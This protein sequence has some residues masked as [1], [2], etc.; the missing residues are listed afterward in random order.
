[1]LFRS[2]YSNSQ[3]PTVASCYGSA[4]DPYSTPGAPK[5]WLFTQNAGQSPNDLVML[6]EFDINTRTLTGVTMDLFTLSSNMPGY[7]PGT[8]GDQTIAGGAT[9]YVDANNKFV[10][11]VDFQQS[12]NLVAGLELA[13]AGAPL[14][15]DVRISSISSPS[16]GMALGIEDVIVNVQNL[17]TNAQSNIPFTVTVDG[18]SFYSGTVAGPLAMGESTAVNCGT[19][20]LSEELGVW[21]FEA[22]TMM[23]GDEN[24]ENDCKTKTVTHLE[25]MYCDAST[26]NQDEYISNV[27]C[28]TIDNSS[29][30]QGG[31]ADYTAISTAIAAG[32]TEAITVTN[33]NPWGS[34]KVT[35]WVDWNKNYE[36]DGGDEM[37]VLTSNAGGA[38]FTGNIAVPTGTPEGDYRMRVRMSYSTDPTPCG[39]M[40]YGEVEDYT[41]HV[42]EAA[43][44]DVGVSALNMGGF[45]EPGVV[46]PKA[47]VKN[48]GS[49]TQTFNV[50][51]TIGSYTS[52]KSVTALVSGAT[53]EVTFDS[54]TAT[55]GSYTAEACTQLAGDENPANNCK[56]MSIT[57]ATGQFVYAYNAYD[58]SG[59][60]V[61]GPVTFDVVNPGNM[62]LLAPTST[63]DFIAGAT[64]ANGTWYGCMYGGGLYTI[65]TQTGA[66]VLVGSS[67]DLGGLAWDGTTMYGASTTDLYTI[68]PATGAGT[69]IGA[70]GNASLM[71]GIAADAAGNIYGYDIGDD[72]F[73]SINKTTG[74]ATIV[75]PLG[76]DFNYA[77]DMAYDK[78]NDVCYLAGYTTTG[79]LFSVDVTT[80]AAT[81]LAEFAGGAEITGFAIPDEGT[82]PPVG[83][84]PIN[85]AASYVAGTG[86]N[87]SWEMPAVA[88]D[89]IRWDD[90]ENSGSLGLEE[91]GTFWA[92]ARWEP[93]DLAAFN[94]Q[95]ITE[96][97]LFPV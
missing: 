87:T 55:V 68:D 12:P 48:F 1:M 80:G 83:P 76:H 85:F 9:S 36:F 41:I 21:V 84:P 6:E 16:T 23:A 93:A 35:V 74:A 49:T 60:I 43:A 5:L 13:T 42:G 61:E 69:L 91:P 29:G 45:Y 70:M 62:N 57:V 33:G 11:A 71:I 79:G 26:N 72:N 25:P 77:Q 89:W 30:W 50:T 7:I 90:G 94:G 32:Q 14:T 66:M 24:P 73:Y 38:N 34:D 52:T 67:P 65:D 75:G 39:P 47:T 8:S 78:V 10:I 18:A 86:V 56:S 20:D 53:Q 28:G 3:T 44:K 81:F 97:E 63:A 27:L 51:M 31:V 59:V 22:C 95:F 15:N 40:S 88:G 19:I 92:A 46:T 82:A 2:L 54:W 37:F 17:G 4:Y 58:P 64:W 96:V